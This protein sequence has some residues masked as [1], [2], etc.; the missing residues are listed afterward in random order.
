MVRRAPVLHPRHDGNYSC[1]VGFLG[2]MAMTTKSPTMT[3]PT[4]I[5]RIGA[6]PPDVGW[7]GTVGMGAGGTGVNV[8]CC[9]AGVGG[10]GSVGWPGAVGNGGGNSAD[11]GNGVGST[12]MT[13]GV[14]TTVGSSVTTGVSVGLGPGGEMGDWN[15]MEAPDAPRLAVRSAATMTAHAN[16]IQADIVC[17]GFCLDKFIVSPP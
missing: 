3:R 12:M 16:N 2:E 17:G 4:M 1:E 5:H 6:G 10:G 14:R 11:V 13:V 15:S 8:G 7:G 9:T